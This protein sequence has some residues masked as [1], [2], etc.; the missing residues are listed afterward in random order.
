MEGELALAGPEL[1]LD[2][3]ERQAEREYI[4]AH[5]FED[6]LHLVEPRL[7]QILVAL[8]DQADLGRLARPGRV[9]RLEPRVVELEHVKLDLEA[10]HVVKPRLD[11]LLQRTAIKMGGR[12]RRRLAV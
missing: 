2:R 10:R 6:R 9:R 4:A 7:G 8:R 11:E 5:R 3:A 1:N 12:E